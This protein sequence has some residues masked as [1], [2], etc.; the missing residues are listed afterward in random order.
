MRKVF[1]YQKLLCRKSKSIQQNSLIIISLLTTSLD[2]H[3][4][5]SSHS[6]V[7]KKKWQ[8]KSE[9]NVPSEGKIK[10][11]VSDIEI[12]KESLIR[13]RGL[14]QREGNKG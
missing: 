6:C 8:D 3:P 11:I 7:R 5:S 4:T 9:N 1:L 10:L 2:Y 14:G 13:F 12:G